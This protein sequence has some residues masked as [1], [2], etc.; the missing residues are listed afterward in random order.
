MTASFKTCGK[1]AWSSDKLTILVITGIKMS[2]VPFEA[3]AGSR[4]RSQD[5]DIVEKIML[6]STLDETGRYLL[7]F[8]QE[9]LEM[10]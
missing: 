6:D 3:E 1:R 5:F 2:T 10:L 7:R 8:E 4:S 9:T